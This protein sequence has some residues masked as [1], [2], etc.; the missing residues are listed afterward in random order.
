MVGLNLQCIH[1]ARIGILKANNSQRK[2]STQYKHWFTGLTNFLSESWLQMDLT[3]ILPSKLVAVKT[4]EQ[5]YSGMYKSLRLFNL[6]CF[7]NKKMCKW[8][9]T[10]LSNRLTTTA[11][12]KKT[13]NTRTVGNFENCELNTESILIYHRLPFSFVPC[14]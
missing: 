12:Q 14:V 8:V 1:P 5:E 2:L 7:Y 3:M 10:L 9:T 4:V 6:T 13:T 11:K